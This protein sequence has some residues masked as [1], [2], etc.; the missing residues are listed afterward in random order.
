[1]PTIGDDFKVEIL[2][3]ESLVNAQEIKVLIRKPNT[4]VSDEKTPTSLDLV[5]SIVKYSIT[6]IYNNIAGEWIFK[7]R[8]KNSEGYIS[9]S[10]NEAT[11]GS[12]IVD[13]LP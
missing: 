5:N 10:I 6:S 7:V 8:I 12:V 9:T 1:M 2:V 13:D 3:N 4:I 11:S